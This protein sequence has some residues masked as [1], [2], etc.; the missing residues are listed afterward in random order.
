MFLED[1]VGQPRTPPV[2]PASSKAKLWQRP[3]LELPWPLECCPEDDIVVV[4]RV[5]VAQRL[6]SVTVSP[7]T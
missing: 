4:L 2:A 6:D 3:V 7:A 1:S 5:C